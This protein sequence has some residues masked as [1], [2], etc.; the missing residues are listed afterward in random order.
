MNANKELVRTKGTMENTAMFSKVSKDQFMIDISKYSY[1]TSPGCYDEI[2]LPE[3]ATEGSAGYDIFMP[4]SI[5]INPGG[6]CTIPTGIKVK[7]DPGTFL[8]LV[9]RSSLGFKFQLGMANTVGIIDS[10]YCNNPEN[11][12]HIMARLVNHGKHAV[13][14]AKGDAFC[15]GIILPFGLTANDNPKGKRTGGL[16]STDKEKA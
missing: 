15:Q 4:F 1:I 5:T 7:L 12:G 11:E 13:H 14:L 3:R 16:G 9:P 8:M 2:E 6:T 10:D